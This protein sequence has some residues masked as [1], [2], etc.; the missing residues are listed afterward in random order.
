MV[1]LELQFN[2]EILV[3][4]QAKTI[5]LRGYTGKPIYSVWFRPETKERAVFVDEVKYVGCLKCALFVEN[6]F[7]I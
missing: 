5:E 1:I 7:A 6:T 4:E 3:Q 2:Y